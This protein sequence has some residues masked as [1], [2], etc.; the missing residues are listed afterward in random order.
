MHS[1]NEASDSDS[2][3]QHKSS[4]KKRKRRAAT[5]ESDISSSSSSDEDSASDV[6]ADGTPVEDGVSRVAKAYAQKGVRSSWS[7]SAQRNQA[8]VNCDNH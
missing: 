8:N 3:I 1:G 5:S 6:D 4:R 2:D 7:R